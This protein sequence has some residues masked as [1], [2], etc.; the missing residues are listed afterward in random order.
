MR[1]D[2]GRT[3]RADDDFLDRFQELMALESAAF[4]DGH[5]FRNVQRDAVGRAAAADL[6]A[7]FVGYSAQLAGHVGAAFLLRASFLR[8]RSGRPPMMTY[9][10]QF[11]PSA[12]RD[13]PLR[14]PRRACGLRRHR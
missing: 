7:R 6:S 9:R 4:P 14:D 11:K 13:K 10:E 1:C 3:I 12:S 2:D 5:P 8:F